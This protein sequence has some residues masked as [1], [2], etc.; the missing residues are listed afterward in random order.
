M[1][2]VA[3]GNTGMQICPLIYGTLTLGPLQANLS[4][5]E[6]GRLIRHALERGVNMVDTAELYGSYPHI[7]AAL[8]GYGGEVFIASKTHAFTGPEARAQVEKGLR[9]LGIERFDLLHLHWANVK[10][11]FTE[12]AEVFEEVVKLRDE[13][14]V[15]H[16]GLSSHYIS[17]VVSAAEVDEIE[18]IH[19]L[20]N[21][22]GLGLRDGSADDMAAAIALA[23]KAGKGIYAMK[24][25]AGGNLIADARAAIR[26]VMGLEGVDALAIGMTSEAEIDANLALV[27]ENVAEPAVWEKLEEKKRRIK[28]STFICQGCGECVE[29]CTNEAITVCDGMAVVDEEKC[30]LCGYCAPA[31]PDFGIRVI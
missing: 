3:L 24:A 29:A 12:R 27:T 17:T 7:K 9:E 4:P 8:D 14:K 30:I 16:L 31:C 28:V 20:I 1:K 15:A 19:P 10:A 5:A 26:Y 25:L 11:P 21:R 6:G 18:V 22:E 13:G 2:K 23:S